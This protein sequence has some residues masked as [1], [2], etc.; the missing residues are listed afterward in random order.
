[1]K[2]GADD[3][4]TLSPLHA[5]GQPQTQRHTQPQPSHSSHGPPRRPRVSFDHHERE[6]ERSETSDSRTESVLTVK[7]RHGFF[8]EFELIKQPTMAKTVSMQSLMSPRSPD[9][10]SKPCPCRPSS[11]LPILRWVPSYSF[12][13][14]K[15]DIMAA[16]TVSILQVPQVLAYAVLAGLPP[17][18]GLYA[19]IVPVIVYSIWSTSTKVAVGPGAPSAIMLA[20]ACNAV[21]DHYGKLPGDDEAMYQEIAMTFTFCCGLIFLALGALRAGF[22]V[23]FLS[24]PVMTG[25]IMSASFIIMLSQCRSLMG[26]DIGRYPIFYENLIAVIE[27]IETIHWWTL[28]ISCGSLFV[29]FLPKC[30]P[31]PRWVPLPL[32]V[33]VANILLSY[34]LDFASLGVATIGAEISSGFPSP[35]M[36]NLNYLGDVFHSA[37]IV[38]IV[39][40]MSNIVLAKSFEQKTLNSH[41]LQKAQFEA[42]AHHR[43]EVVGDDENDD[44]EVE[45]SPSKAPARPLPLAPIAVD[46]NMEFVAY[47]VANLLGSMF[48]SQLISASFSRTAL[49]YETNA[50]TRVAGLLRAVVCLLCALFL[51]PLLS[52]LPKCVLASV[53]CTAVYRLMTSGIAEAKFLLRVSRL[54]LIEFCVS[55]LAPLVIGMEMGIFLA[56]ATSIIVNLLRHT[57]ASVVSLGALKTHGDN[58]EAQYVEL[59]QFASARR[60]PHIEVIEIKAELS[61]TNSLRLVE[62]LREMVMSEGERYIVVSLNLTSFIDT[63]AIREIIVLFS[64][65]KDAFICLSQCRPKVISL[66]RKYQ[67]HEERFPENVKT[68]ISTHDAVRYLRKKRREQLDVGEDFEVSEDEESDEEDELNIEDEQV[69]VHVTPLYAPVTAGVR[70]G[71]A[72][73][74]AEPGQIGNV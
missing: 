52:P 51:M 72:S 36:P 19:S 27:N 71:A 14:L 7:S 4:A 16:L 1:M 9:A 23:V 24:R 67:K 20:S 56:I 50:Q 38:T 35:K 70:A 64:D 39:D 31:I 22:V 41:R 42:Y 18:W 32:L 62:R 6:V 37:L 54:E 61:F 63:T 2:A 33:M 57:F 59:K 34:F 5:P 45:K 29:L 30:L 10:S 25:F 58:E 44:D 13:W 43:V 8:S 21:M 73:H 60:V 53:V 3:T 49:N 26:L 46:S 47:G 55:V 15:A 66:I 40:Y 17:E 69:Q 11:L 65:A 48:S 28:G 74:E 12:A 68:F